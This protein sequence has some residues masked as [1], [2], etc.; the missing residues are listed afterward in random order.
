M[1][2]DTKSVL[3][4]EAAIALHNHRSGKNESLAEPKLTVQTLGAVLYP[5]SGYDSIKQSMW[6]LTTGQ[7]KKINPEWVMQICEVTGVDA[8]F[9]FGTPSKHDKEYESL[10]KKPT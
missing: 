4:V 9:L 10:E 3:R 5:G 2:T 6:K 1:A 7:L 8:N